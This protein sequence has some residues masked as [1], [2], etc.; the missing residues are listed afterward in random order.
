MQK[1]EKERKIGPGASNR[2]HVPAPDPAAGHPETVPGRSSRGRRLL[3]HT[4]T[5]LSSF[6][7]KLR[8][9][10]AERLGRPHSY[11][12]ASARPPYFPRPLPRQRGLFGPLLLIL[13]RGHRPSVAET[14]TSSSPGRY[15]HKG[16]SPPPSALGPPG[17]GVQRGRADSTSVVPRALVRAGYARGGGA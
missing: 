7:T 15:L 16:A 10:R 4:A 17:Y 1:Q 2:K 11:P 13:S 12:Q 8:P 6:R 14:G 3:H 9:P 5:S